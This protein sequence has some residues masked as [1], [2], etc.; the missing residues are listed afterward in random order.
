[1]VRPAE[2]KALKPNPK[3]VGRG[4]GV[5]GRVCPQQRSWCLLEEDA[6]ISLPAAPLPFRGHPALHS[7]GARSSG[8][9]PL[10]TFRLLLNSHETFPQA[11][12]ANKAFANPQNV[13]MD[14]RLRPYPM[15]ALHFHKHNTYFANLT[16]CQSPQLLSVSSGLLDK[17]QRKQTRPIS[18]LKV[19][20]QRARH[21]ASE[22]TLPRV[23]ST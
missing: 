7:G 4:G 8:P 1:M 18:P 10:P 14:S 21:C 12:F 15:A 16:S 11:G 9:V 2:N 23:P 6:A 19:C 22:K 3:R 13:G 5:L 17:S 20:K